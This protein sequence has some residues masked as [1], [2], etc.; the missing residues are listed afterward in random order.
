[1]KQAIYIY[2]YESSLKLCQNTQELL[3]D[4]TIWNFWNFKTQIK[5]EGKKSS[6]RTQSFYTN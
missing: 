5:R 6:R 4:C 3:K 2:I 1:L